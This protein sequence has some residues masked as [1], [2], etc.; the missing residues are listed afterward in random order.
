MS[1][2]MIAS[3]IIMTQLFHRF[4]RDGAAID[5]PGA[6]FLAA[7]LVALG[8]FALGAREPAPGSVASESDGAIS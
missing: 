6:P 1:L 4:S 2:T 7:A 5:F 3:P 8:L